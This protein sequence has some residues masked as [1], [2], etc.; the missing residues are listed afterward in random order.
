MFTGCLSL[1]FSVGF[2]TLD[3]SM[4]WSKNCPS[5]NPFPS[6]SQAPSPLFLTLSPSLS[7]SCKFAYFQPRN[8]VTHV[9]LNPFFSRMEIL[10][11]KILK[12]KIKS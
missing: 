2:S 12:I 7:C 5:R 4:L 8:Y 9:P 3:I 6:V 10:E 1:R 11:I